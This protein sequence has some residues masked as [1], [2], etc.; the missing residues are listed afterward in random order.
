[1]RTRHD[2]LVMSLS[3]CIVVPWY[4][5]R[6]E[7]TV[8]YIVGFTL[9]PRTF[10]TRRCLCTHFYAG[11]PWYAW[12]HIDD[13]HHIWNTF[14]GPS[15]A[16]A[17]VHAFHPRLGGL[18]VMSRGVMEQHDDGGCTPQSVERTYTP[19][20]NPYLCR[21]CVHT[22]GEN[23][24]LPFHYGLSCLFKL[25]SLLSAPSLITLGDDITCSRRLQVNTW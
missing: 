3:Q 24:F 18:L 9:I 14:R 16:D 4:E 7:R 2:T 20:E 13:H 1:M 23:Q 15:E 11:K 17:L 8:S 10:I 25:Q 19:F 5:T 6:P 12:K 22:E 21:I